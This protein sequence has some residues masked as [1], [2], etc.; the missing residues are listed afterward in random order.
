MKSTNSSK[1]VAVIYPYETG[2]KAFSG[3][4]PKVVVSNIIA[5]K[6]MGYIPY[7]ILPPDNNGL[8]SFI[9]QNHRYCRIVKVKFK[10]LS[11]FSDTKGFAR[12]KPIINNLYGFI[13]GKGALKEAVRKIKPD[14]I[15][16]HEIINFPILNIYPKSK[17]VLHIHSYRFTEYKVL[18]EAI[19]KL[20]NKHTDIVL[21]P[22]KSI[23]EAI[24]RRLNVKAEVID[25]PYLHLKSNESNNKDTIDELTKFKDKHKIIYAF[26]GRICS[27][28]RIDHFIEAISKLDEIV[29]NRLLFIIIGGTNTAGDVL[30]KSSLENDILR[31][32]L[33]ENVKFVGYVDPIEDILTMV[34]YGVILSESE[35][36]PMIGIE[37]MRFNI[38]IIGYDAPGIN[39]F[40]IDKKNGF[41]V[42]NGNIE[43]LSEALE[44][45]VTLKRDNH[46]HHTIPKIF[47][48]H[49]IT[50]FTCNLN[51]IYSN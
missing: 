36:V 15:H 33:S 35:A 40:L 43:K 49:S 30:Y 8:I 2:G 3:G 28:K 50:N 22:T 18:L 14:I 19:F 9:Y 44:A 39:D 25:T 13:K 6:E 24:G 26:A 51:R 38:P 10:S 5:I 45:T 42:D 23:L 47:A 29:K 27:I 46:F 17:T 48:R 16:F 32:G 41:L 34:D 4:V 21:S 12:L 1:K 7:V 31:F 37:F 20:V 11:F